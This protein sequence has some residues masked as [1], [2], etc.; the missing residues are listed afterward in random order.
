M[1]ELLSVCFPPFP[2]HVAVA[3]LDQRLDPAALR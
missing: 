3:Q 1:S 2:C